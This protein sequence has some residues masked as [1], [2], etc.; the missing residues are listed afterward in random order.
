[1]V[2]VLVVHSRKNPQVHY[3]F[4]SHQRTR[5]DN[6]VRKYPADRY[7]AFGRMSFWLAVKLCM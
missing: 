2:S 4:W 1:M 6:F 7:L 3:Y 5:A